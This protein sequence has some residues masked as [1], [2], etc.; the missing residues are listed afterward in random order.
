MWAK[1]NALYQYRSPSYPEFAFFYLPLPKYE[2]KRFRQRYN[3]FMNTFEFMDDLVR[4]R[5]ILMEEKSDHR[6]FRYE[7]PDEEDMQDHLI[8]RLPK[9][10]VIELGAVI[11]G[12]MRADNEEANV[13][14]ERVVGD[15]KEALL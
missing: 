11:L 12:W 6:V 1:T 3:Q 10:L 4:S 5:L 7:W 9:G 15:L 8:G 14:M 13:F 2:Q